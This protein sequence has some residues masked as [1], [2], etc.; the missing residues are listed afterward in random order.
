[1]T[2][3]GPTNAVETSYMTLLTARNVLSERNSSPLRKA[4]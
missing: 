3:I 1:M 2:V 4:A